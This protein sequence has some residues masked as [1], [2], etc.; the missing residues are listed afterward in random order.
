ML[1]P[2]SLLSIHRWIALAFAPLLILQVV[3]GMML[4]FRDEIMR[5]S[6]PAPN[7]ESAAT[8]P[9]SAF[10]SSAGQAFPQMRL[11]RLFF[12]AEIGS[13]VF[14]QLET[15]DGSTRYAALA[16]DK[17][18]VLRHGSIMRF[19]FE[20]ALQIH[21][22]LLS[23]PVGI[24]VVA[25]NGLALSLLSVSGVWH[26][27]PGVTRIRRALRI[28]ARGPANL[29]LRAWH[30]SVGAVLAIILLSTS[31]TGLMLSLPNLPLTGSSGAPASAPV[32][33][34]APEIDKVFAKAQ[35]QFPGSKPRDVRFRPDGS[36]AVNFFAPRGG[37]WAVDVA[38]VKAGQAATAQ[39]LTLEENDA[40]W[41][42]ALPV[43]TGDT[44][45]PAGRWLMLAAALALLFLAT[46]GPLAWWR[47]RRKGKRV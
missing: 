18:T 43:H 37:K 28:P 25:L 22:R 6:I 35:A 47:L 27:W 5:L 44:V 15:A 14:A 20:A 42:I 38:T 12:P 2:R 10:T 11:T 16:P 17:A 45:G 41:L 21:F 39:R 36:L 26:W 9:L 34:A 13:A 4:L 24:A 33:L 19:P 7:P 32:T 31:V 3:T 40:L 8:A 30:R 1:K 23:G 46:S 29:K